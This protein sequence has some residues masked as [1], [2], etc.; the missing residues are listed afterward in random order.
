M[1]DYKIATE[2]PLTTNQP[3]NSSPTE[4]FPNF[5]H[6][7]RNRPFQRLQK[8]G[9]EALRSPRSWDNQVF[10]F[11]RFFLVTLAKRSVYFKLFKPIA[12]CFFEEINIRN[13]FF[14]IGSIFH[15]LLLH[16]RRWESTEVA[17][18]NTKVALRFLVQNLCKISVQISGYYL[19]A[20]SRIV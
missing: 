7:G 6:H 17:R 4:E 1:I 5:S 10:V 8:W 3:R 2:R 13:S 18:E 15:V 11:F 16:I 14:P 20:V 9:P 19:G 12:S